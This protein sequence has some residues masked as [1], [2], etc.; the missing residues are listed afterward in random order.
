MKTTAIT[1]KQQGPTP[2][3]VRT[4]SNATAMGTEIKESSCSSFRKLQ[5]C[6]YLQQDTLTSTANPYNEIQILAPSFLSLR[7]IACS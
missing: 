1:A 6:R 5:V 2:Q 4:C 3:Q 7:Y